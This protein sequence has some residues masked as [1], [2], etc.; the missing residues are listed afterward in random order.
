MKRWGLFLLRVTTGWLLVMWGL[1]KLVNVAHG[2]AVAEAFYLGIGTQA[3]VQNVFGVL[4]II[5]GALVVL[6]LW[7]RRAYPVAFIV[8]AITALGVWRSIIDPWGWVLEGS[9]VLFY[10]SAI[11]AAGAL[12]LWGTIDEDEMTLDAKM[13][14]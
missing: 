5:L 2:Q 11:I 6:G 13:T 8:V 9:N 7:R 4:Q 14:S 10:P 12:L 3:A 1:D